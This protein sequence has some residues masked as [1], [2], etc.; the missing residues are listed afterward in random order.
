MT[1]VLFVP[2]LHHVTRD[3]HNILR[4]SSK[5]EH[6]ATAMLK[7]KTLLAFFKQYMWLECIDLEVEDCVVLSLG[8][9]DGSSVFHRSD[10]SKFV[11]LCVMLEKHKD[12]VAILPTIPYGQRHE[13]PGYAII[14][15]DYLDMFLEAFLKTAEDWLDKNPSTTAQLRR[16]FKIPQTA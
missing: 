15:K 2:L 13:Q 5:Y 8:F 16:L 4:P 10:I 14:R 9:E 12:V 11:N 7:A 3:S 1:D 6:D